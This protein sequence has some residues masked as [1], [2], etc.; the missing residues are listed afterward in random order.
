MIFMAHSSQLVGP[1]VGTTMAGIGALTAVVAPDPATGMTGVTIGIGGILLGGATLITAFGDKIAPHLLAYAKLRMDAREANRQ[2]KQALE[3]ATA[4]VADLTA[5]LDKV[6][7]Q[8]NLF[9]NLAIEAK[10]EAKAVE[11]TAAVR[12]AETERRVRSNADRVAAIEPRV[13]TL[14]QV[15]AGTSSDELPIPSP[16]PPPP[17]LP[18]PPPGAIS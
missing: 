17:P 5:Q 16:P 1:V 7:E 6:R 18:P 13:E 15:Q 9:E 4:Q 14:E 12:I 11:R 2:A 3:I 10:A 8:M